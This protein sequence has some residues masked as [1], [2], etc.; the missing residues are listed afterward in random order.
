MYNRA[1]FTLKK[2]ERAHSDWLLLKNYMLYSK[3][4]K[5]KNQ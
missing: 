2:I 3:V 5:G 4:K 1:F